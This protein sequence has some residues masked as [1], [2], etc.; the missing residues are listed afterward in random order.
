MLQR[1][2][3][4]GDDFAVKRRFLVS[5]RVR[6]NLNKNY[7]LG[8]STNNNGTSITDK[9]IRQAPSLQNLRKI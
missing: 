1:V 9:T 6:P 7:L 8:D 2:W 5:S 4:S 3:R